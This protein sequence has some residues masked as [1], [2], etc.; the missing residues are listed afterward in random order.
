MDSG[1][2]GVPAR[3]RTVTPV[4]TLGVASMAA[5]VLTWGLQ[6]VAG[7]VLGPE[8]YAAFMVVWGFVFFSVGVL[9]GLQQEVARPSRPPGPHPTTVRAAP[10]SG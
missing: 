10:S 7:R 8:S 1:A 9:A 5:A 3:S 6:A 4:L 2:E